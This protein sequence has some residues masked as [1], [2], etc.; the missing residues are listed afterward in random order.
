[1]NQIFTRKME[2]HGAEHGKKVE[3]FLTIGRWG[4]M[5]PPKGILCPRGEGWGREFNMEFGA[6]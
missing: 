3:T 2:S 1:M 4:E 5:V 6:R